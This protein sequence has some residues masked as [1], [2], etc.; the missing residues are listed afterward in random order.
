MFVNSLNIM[1]VYSS[2]IM[3]LKTAFKSDRTGSDCVD[4]QVVL[5]LLGATDVV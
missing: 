3:S 4:A 2:N 1:C 5:S